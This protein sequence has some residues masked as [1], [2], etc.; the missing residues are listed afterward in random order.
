M[1]WPTRRGPGTKVIFL[2]TDFGLEG[3]YVGQMRAAIA[4]R[5]PDLAVVDLC[6]DLAPFDARAA[7]YLLAALV[8]ELPEACALVGVVDP[9]VGTE[10]EPVMLRADGRIFVGP[11]NGL[12]A[13]AARG[14][15]KPE[16]RRLTWRPERLSRSFHGRDLFAPAAARILLGDPPDTTPLEADPVGGDWPDRHE[17]VIYIDRYGNAI[18]GITA[19]EVPRE[20]KLRMGDRTLSHAATFGAVPRG[21]AFWYENSS[22]LV[23]IAVNQGRADAGMG[24]RVGTAIELR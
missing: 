5:A 20:A 13:L 10:R 21:E 17:A 18:T 4:R 14:A 22:G 19:R 8:P 3:P 16:W 7:A 9:G 6:H 12:F 24:I 11:D 15:A 23:E 1:L 2:Y